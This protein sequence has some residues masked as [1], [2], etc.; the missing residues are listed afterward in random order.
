M[1]YCFLYQ[2]SVHR[3]GFGSDSVRVMNRPVSGPRLA[4]RFSGCSL[5]C[6]QTGKSECDSSG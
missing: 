3:S 4:V 6:A 5:R 2:R 1:R